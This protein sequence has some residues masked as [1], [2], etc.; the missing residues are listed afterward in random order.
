M[1][2]GALVDTYLLL[3]AAA[4]AGRVIRRRV[5]GCEGQVIGRLVGSPSGLRHSK[6]CQRGAAAGPLVLVSVPLPQLI[7]KYSRTLRARAKVTVRVS[8]WRSL[9][10]PDRIPVR[11][12][13]RSAIWSLP[14]LC[15][16]RLQ[17][18]LIISSSFD[19]L[20]VQLGKFVWYCQ[21]N[22]TCHPWT[23]FLSHPSFASISQSTQSA[24][25]EWPR[26]SDIV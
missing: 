19:E 10:I 21:Q 5:Y 15:H 4:A 17:K 16:G 7:G 3:A 11:R 26:S 12:L 20:L 13:A 18:R 9:G 24:W 14:R 23:V 8:R 25:D 22:R 1:G 6:G 2:G